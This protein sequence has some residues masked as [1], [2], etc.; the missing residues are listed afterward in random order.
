MSR[1]GYI[2]WLI[3]VILPCK[4]IAQGLIFQNPANSIERRTSFDVFNHDEITFE[5]YLDITFDMQLPLAEEVGYIVRIIDRPSKQIYN[6]FYDGRGNDYFELNEEGRKCIIMSP[7]NRNELRRKQWFKVRLLFDMEH[8]TISLTIDG[9]QHSTRKTSLPGQLTPQIIFGRSDYLID[10]PSFAM[11]NLIIRSSNHSY[12]FPLSQ[13]QGNDVYTAAGTKRGYVLNPHWRINDAYHWRQ[14]LSYSSRTVAGANFNARRQEVYYYNSDTLFIYSLLSRQFR[15]IPF[16]S[17]CP[18]QLYL[19]TNFIDESNNRLYTYETFR[20]GKRDEEPS[21]ASL[22]LDTYRWNTEA[23]VQINEGQM[24]HHGSYFDPHRGEY[25]IYGG[26]ANM[27][28]NDMFYTYNVNDH[29]WTMRH[30]IRGE[31]FPRYFQ[32]MGYDKSRYVYIFGGMGNES[33]DQT[34]GR[35]FFYDLHRL[36]TRTNKVEK[37]WDLDWGN[38][39]NVVVARGMVIRGPYFYVLCY[40]EFLSD[41]W[42]KLY[43]F[44]LRDGSHQLLGD[45]IPIHPDRIETDANLYYDPLLRQFV[46]TV[47]EFSNEKS[48]QLRAYAINDPVLTEAQFAQACKLPPNRWYP[49]LAVGAL[50]LTGGGLLAFQRA[51]RK[52]KQQLAQFSSRPEMEEEPQRPNSVC[53]FGEFT[54]HNRN[55]HDITYLFTDKLKQVFCLL[56]QYSDADGISSRRLGNVMWGEKPPEKIKNSRSVAINHLRKVLQELDGIEVVYRNGYFKLQMLPPLYCDYTE[57][58]AI[59]AAGEAMERRT[60]VLTILHR[61]KFLEFM[62]MPAMD[63]FKNETDERLVPTLTEIMK[64]SFSAQ[65]YRVTIWCIEELFVIDPINERAFGCQQKVLKRMSKEFELQEARRRFHDEYRKLMGEE[66]QETDSG[67]ILPLF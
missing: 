39:Q 27:R 49:W 61:G 24:H 15:K 58:K 21:I 23:I 42:L 60:E 43:R 22:N 6:V 44:S 63:S 20:E 9:K 52:R 29:H 7:F 1:A 64:Q 5:Q 28:Y 48:S 62:N 66:Y 37:L 46:A 3:A 51:R 18:V 19:G 33:G 59:L 17:P 53:L 12:T 36:D 57:L 35:R 31:K 32:A 55:N 2:L 16:A 38:R 54:V 11:K 50:L 14:L 10:V 40:S 25:T 26:F 13:A 34:V 56:L 4:T 45:S 67:S 30:D 8:K 41:S 47:L 65:E